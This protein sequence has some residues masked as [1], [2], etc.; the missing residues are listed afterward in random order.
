MDTKVASF[1]DLKNRGVH[2]NVKLAS[3]SALKNPSLLPKLMVAAGLHEDEQYA[4]SLSADLWNAAGFPEYAYK[5]ELD[6]AQKELN[7]KNEAQSVGKQ[8]EFI[9]AGISNVEDTS[10]MKPGVSA[11]ERVMAGLTRAKEVSPAKDQ[12]RGKGRWDERETK[13]RRGP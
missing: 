4:S 5:E 10:V 9:P 13:R 6:K 8:R 7:S 11:A 3:S 1:R 2:F 12:T